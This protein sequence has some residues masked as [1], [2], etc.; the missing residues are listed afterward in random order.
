MLSGPD[1]ILD[2]SLFKLPVT[3]RRRSPRVR[4]LVLNDRER[5]AT[6]ALLKSAASC[7]SRWA[8]FR[9]TEYGDQGAT[10]YRLACQ[11]A[12]GTRMCP[13]CDEK[14]RRRESWRVE[15]SWAMFL[16]F[17]LPPEVG[18]PEECWRKVHGF[19]S[20]L[21]KRLRK[22]TYGSTDF[23]IRYEREEVERIQ[24]INRG[25]PEKNRQLP[26]FQ[27]AW[28]MEPHESGRP[29]VH[30]VVNCAYIHYPWLLKAW[31]KATKNARSLFDGRK[32]WQKDGVC[33]YLCKYISKACLPPDVLGILKRRR[34]WATSVPR[35]P[36]PPKRWTREEK[37]SADAAWLDALSGRTRDDADSW[38]LEMTKEG[39][40]AIWSRPASSFCDLRNVSWE[41][42]EAPPAVRDAL[43]VPS[44]RDLLGS[45]LK[46]LG[47]DV[48][49]FWHA[50]C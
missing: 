1:G 36:A 39:G 4:F 25:I 15:G 23:P 6:R 7:G 37:T 14:I 26:I 49:A 10:E 43:P 40:Y 18:T 44:L 17:T 47:M 29:H 21:L 16:T 20:K 34:L 48:D 8:A 41:L 42:D 19:I 31:R 12:C 2:R 13:A 46:E 50:P 33:R 11:V 22:A 3:D 9:R 24:E 27:Y 28:A 45:L 38:T 35:P 5:N 32:V 30:M